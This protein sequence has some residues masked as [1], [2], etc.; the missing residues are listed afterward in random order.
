MIIGYLLNF[1]QLAIEQQLSGFKFDDGDG[2][3][4]KIHHPDRVIFHPPAAVD[5][6]H[7]LRLP[8]LAEAQEP[9]DAREVERV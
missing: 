2:L 7:R 3:I 1:N 5:L 9:T 6:Q 4:V 8:F